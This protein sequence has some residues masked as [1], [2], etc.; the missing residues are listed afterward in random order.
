MRIN[1]PAALLLSGTVLLVSG[2]N[3]RAQDASAQTTTPQATPTA[4][5]QP[6]DSKSNQPGATAPDPSADANAGASA[7][8]KQP[9]NQVN[10]VGAK[11]PHKSK[12]VRPGSYANIPGIPNVNDKAAPFKFGAM[13]EAEIIRDPAEAV[14]KAK[15]LHAKAMEQA[16]AKSFSE[17]EATEKEAITAAPHF[18][19]PHAG[20]VYIMRSEGKKPHELINEANLSLY[21]KPGAVAQRN[22]GR[23]FNYL[24]WMPP[25][26]KALVDATNNDPKNWQGWLQLCDAWIA[27]NNME[28]AQQSI[29][30]IKP[31]CLSI[32]ECVE[33]IGVRQ[34][35]M[36][37]AHHAVED[38]QK[39]LAMPNVSADTKKETNE[40]LFVAA[41]MQENV[42]LVEQTFNQLSDTYKQERPELVLQA[43]TMLAKDPA[44]ADDLIKQAANLQNAK[45]D[46]AFFIVCRGLIQKATAATDPAQQKA[47][48]I[49]AEEADKNAISRNTLDTKYRIVEASLQDQLGNNTA[50]RQS[51][52]DMKEALPT[53]L[54]TFKIDMDTSPQEVQ[55]H[56]EAVLRANLIDAFPLMRDTGD[57]T[58]VAYHSNAR[59][60]Q[61]QILKPSCSCHARSLKRSMEQQPGVF[62]A[63][64]SKDK[65]PIISVYY[66]G[67]Q[68]SEKKLM[69][70]KII[71]SIGD[72]TKEVGDKEITSLKDIG[73][74]IVL[75]E[76]VKPVMAKA[77][78]HEL[79]LE[80]PLDPNGQ[81]AE[82]TETNVR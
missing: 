58:T 11:S 78:P 37:N 55:H 63:T 82:T 13:P 18:W 20:M 73:N 33:Q 5:S 64:I 48:L 71:S 61:V 43:N 29:K 15:T 81:V 68:N 6:A 51:L 70:A 12:S 8:S 23:L 66:D 54:K 72:P 41:L 22:A 17:A 57:A 42:S 49:K 56:F 10:T 46:Q 24:H 44:Q 52:S 62:L 67:K 77:Q 45:V 35:M 30:Y 65:M 59:E 21:G 9:I 31:E 53:N 38:F 28:S 80:M 79:N 69:D 60:L 74:V 4:E 1:L 2:A 32:P 7:D 50:V 26:M 75:G 36:G 19:L 3:V 47:W 76:D 14:E 16:K 34:M 27:Q 39:V 40:F 25:A